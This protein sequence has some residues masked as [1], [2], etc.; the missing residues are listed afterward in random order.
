[1]PEY[2]TFSVYGFHTVYP[3]TWKIEFNPKSDRIKGDVAFKSPEKDNIFLSWGP[4]EL[5]KKRFSSLEGHV[6]HS[7]NQIRKDPRVRG[8]DTVKTEEFSIK[9]HKAIYSLLKVTFLAPSMIPLRKGREDV[10][11]MRT[12]NTYCPVSGRYYVL[13]GQIALEKSEEHEAIFNNMVQS[14]RC[15]GH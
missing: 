12:M 3:S 5:A 1:M 7:V 15:H 13:F 11:E 4:L 9:S 2:E 8:V 6:E 14:F 10:M